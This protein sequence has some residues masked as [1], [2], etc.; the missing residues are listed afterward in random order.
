MLIILKKNERK[1]AANPVIDYTAFLEEI[2]E[3]ERVTV[4]LKG[5]GPTHHVH[6]VKIKGSTS[7]TWLVRRHIVSICMEDGLYERTSESLLGLLSIKSF[8]P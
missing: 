3:G 6:E 5:T 1:N 2:K 4:S 8:L 7:Q